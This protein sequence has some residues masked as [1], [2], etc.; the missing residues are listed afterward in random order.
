MEDTHNRIAKVISALKPSDSD[1]TG[2]YTGKPIDENEKPDQ[3]AD[4]L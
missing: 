4:D 1:P 3:D 2:S